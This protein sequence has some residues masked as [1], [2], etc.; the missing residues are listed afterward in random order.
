MQ[1]FSIRDLR[2]RSGDL[3]REAE[4]GR[5]A[6]VTRH[7][8]PLFLS[9]PFTDELLQTGIHV[10]LAV[11]L[12]RTRDLT[13]GKSAKLAGMSLVQFAEHVS[14]LGLAVVDYARDELGD[15]LDTLTRSAH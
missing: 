3:S 5:L 12:F 15:E 14:R 10:A 9:V 13:I 7:G 2:D 4:E 8:Q 1:T 11:S 6:V